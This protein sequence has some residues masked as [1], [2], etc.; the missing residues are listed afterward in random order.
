MPWCPHA[1]ASPLFRCGAAPPERG[2]DGTLPK[3]EV[4]NTL[5][6]YYTNLYKHHIEVIQAVLVPLAR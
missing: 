1:A 4:V 5:P 3:I 6:E 2:G